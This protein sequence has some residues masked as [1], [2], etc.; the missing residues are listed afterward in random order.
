MTRKTI[1]IDGE[2]FEFKKFEKRDAIAWDI[3]DA[4][5]KPSITKVNI[6]RY[7]TDW[8]NRNGFNLK[9]TGANACIF[10]IEA[11]DNAYRMRITREHNYIMYNT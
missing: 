9:I 1:I 2:T 3:W 5:G 4:Y 6:W 11:W 10:T 7:W 8:A